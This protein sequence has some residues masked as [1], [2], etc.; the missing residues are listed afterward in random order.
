MPSEQ[1]ATSTADFSTAGFSAGIRYNMYRAE[2]LPSKEFR[3]D[4]R[5]GAPGSAFEMDVT[6]SGETYRMSAD[7]TAEFY[8]YDVYNGSADQFGVLTEG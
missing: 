8:Y 6:V 2:G 5:M 4:V 3:Y 7:P 1:H